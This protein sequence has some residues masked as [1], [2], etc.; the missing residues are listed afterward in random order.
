M[1]SEYKVV[2]MPG[3]GVVKPEENVSIELERTAGILSA[4][5]GLIKDIVSTGSTKEEKDSGK[6]KLM[7]LRREID[8]RL[9]VIDE[10]IEK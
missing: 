6:Q 4:V 9:T 5:D 3:V 10:I 7:R 8:A 2:N 1:K